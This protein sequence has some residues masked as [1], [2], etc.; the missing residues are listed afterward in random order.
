MIL[1]PIIYC[2]SLQSTQNARRLSTRF[3]VSLACYCLII[4]SIYTN[5]L[6]LGSWPVKLWNEADY[7][8]SESFENEIVANSNIKLKHG[9]LSGGP[10]RAAALSSAW[11]R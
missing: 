4:I 9:R 2:Q 3:A 7:S 8:L 1:N 11:I 5:R 10:K 6:N